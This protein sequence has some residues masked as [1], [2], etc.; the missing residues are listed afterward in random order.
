MASA[1]TTFQYLGSAALSAGS[2]LSIDV[3]PYVGTTNVTF[4]LASGYDLTGQSFHSTEGSV[5]PQLTV[6]TD[7]SAIPTCNTP[8][9]I[10]A[11][12]N[13]LVGT[14][15]PLFACNYKPHLDP[16][17]NQWTVG[18]SQNL[19]VLAAAAAL[20]DA[21]VVNGFD[22]RSWWQTFFFNQ[23]TGSGSTNIQYFKGT[24]LFSNVYDS[25]V[26]AAVIAANYWSYKHSYESSSGT[27]QS[28][29]DSTCDAPGSLGDGDLAAG[30][31]RRLQQ[32]RS[33]PNAGRG[34]RW[35]LP[36]SGTRQSPLVVGLHGRHEAMDAGQVS[37]LQPELR[38]A[39]EL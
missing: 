38:Q 14:G 33:D 17:F 8:G 27:I 1:G 26:V 32:R 21:P 9:K 25:A 20:W 31:Q 37:W 30:V 16:Y 6:V 7:G 35:G 39:G 24:E 5:T 3:T 18:G 13:S 2:D 23:S 28:L 22:Y 4:G 29:A 36:D 19:P 12:I 11:E 15:S 34:R 10:L